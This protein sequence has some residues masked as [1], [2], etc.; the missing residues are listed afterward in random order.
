[1][2][3]LDAIFFGVLGV[4]GGTSSP[5]SPSAVGVAAVVAVFFFVAFYEN[6]SNNI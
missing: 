4:G 5:A 1:M 6:V 2:I 3:R